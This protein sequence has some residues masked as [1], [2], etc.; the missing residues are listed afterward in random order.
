MARPVSVRACSCT[1]TPLR[2]AHV[3]AGARGRGPW[4]AKAGH[5]HDGARRTSITIAA[6]AELRLMG[7][8]PARLRSQDAVT[9]DGWLNADGFVPVVLPDGGRGGPGGFDGGMGGRGAGGIGQGPGGG[10]AGWASGNLVAPPGPASHATSARDRGGDLGERR[11]GG[12]AGFGRQ[13]GLQRGD[14]AGVEAL[15]RGGEVRHLVEAACPSSR[16]WI[17]E[18]SMSVRVAS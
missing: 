7:S 3:H 15:A 9:I 8:N 1:A 6:G 16:R 4:C 18:S 5:G 11:H 10:C 14:P 2:S 13:A 17:G 12:S